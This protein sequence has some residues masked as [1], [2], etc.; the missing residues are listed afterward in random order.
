VDGMTPHKKSR[1]DK[2]KGG[3]SGHKKYPVNSMNVQHL[4]RVSWQKSTCFNDISRLNISLAITNSLFVLWWLA[5]GLILWIRSVAV[6][7]GKH[8]TCRSRLD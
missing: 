4:I 3:N 5:A 1:V 7:I 8:G 2:R 6:K